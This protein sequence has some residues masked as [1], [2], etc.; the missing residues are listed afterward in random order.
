MF[1]QYFCFPNRPIKGGDILDFQKGGNLRKVG[2]DLQN[3]D[4]GYDPP[5]YLTN[6]AYVFLIIIFSRKITRFFQ[7]LPQENFRKFLVTECDDPKKDL[8]KGHFYTSFLNSFITATPQGQLLLTFGDN[9]QFIETLSF[10]IY[11]KC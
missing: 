10:I 11:Q 1:I 7:R 3:E 8:G 6:Y 4:E 2:V 5:Y 9:K